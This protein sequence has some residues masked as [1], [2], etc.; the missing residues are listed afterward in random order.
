MSFFFP[1]GLWVMAWHCKSQKPQQ[2]I[3]TNCIHALVV[4]KERGY[5]A[6][7]KQQ[8]M[9]DELHVLSLGV[10]PAECC[11]KLQTLHSLLPKWDA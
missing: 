11:S 3:D 5:V 8:A 4:R 1:S 9:G 7:L 6:K 10:R 2:Q